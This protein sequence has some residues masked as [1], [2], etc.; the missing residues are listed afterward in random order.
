MET[1]DVLHLSFNQDTTLLTLGSNHGF[2][3][4][5]LDPFELINQE[6]KGNFKIVEM[7]ESSQLLIL[8]GAGEQPAFSTRRLTIWNIAE[9]IPIC[10]TSFPDSIL[11]VKM[12]R[13]R[14]VAVIID[15]IY[16]YN[17]TTMKNQNHIRTV[18]NPKGLVA[19]SPTHSECFLLYPASENKGHV[20]VY[21]CFN[22]QPRTIIEAHNSPLSFIA[23]SYQGQYC[24]TASVKGTMIRVF[25]LPEGNRLFTFKRGITHAEIYN[26]MFSYEANLL[27]ACSSTGTVHVYDIRHNNITQ[28]VGWS[29]SI[30]QSL[31]SAASYFLPETYKDSFETSRSF[32]TARTY[33]NKKFI[34]ALIPKTNYLITVS[35]SQEFMI[36]RINTETGGEAIP[37]HQGILNKMV[38]TQIKQKQEDLEYCK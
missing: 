23:I 34:A 2:K 10:E 19:L 9:R 13:M 26:I 15:G 21:D 29:N 14:I 37:E 28:E 32:I 38:Q 7:Y 6:D 31:V 18:E 33:F 4:Y 22:M 8:V 35:F 17:T 16:I 12:N 27:L 24:A 1:E 5:K 20:Q 3:V 30:K 25:S 11:S 36:F